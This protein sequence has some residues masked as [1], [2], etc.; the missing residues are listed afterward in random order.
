VPDDRG[1]EP[2]QALDLSGLVVGV[3]VKVHLVPGGDRSARELQGKA[4]M[5]APQHPEVIALPLGRGSQVERARPETGHEIHVRAVDHRAAEPDG[6]AESLPVDGPV[7][8]RG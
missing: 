4:A 3:Q 5:V 7:A 8:S 1:P 2:G 6:H